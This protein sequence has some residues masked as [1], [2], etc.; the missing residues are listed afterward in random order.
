MI[1]AAVI[2]NSLIDEGNCLIHVFDCF[3]SMSALVGEGCLELC[4]GL[5]QVGAGSSH[6]GLIRKGQRRE[7]A[8][9]DNNS[10]DT[11]SIQHKKHE[12]PS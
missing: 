6:E 7:S 9:K 2:G 11:S 12:P 5:L 8:E 3:H 4:S 10:Q 1:V